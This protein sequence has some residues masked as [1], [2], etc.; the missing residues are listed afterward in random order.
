[1]STYHSWTSRGQVTVIYD[2]ENRDDIRICYG[3]TIDIE[4]EL[5]A[6]LIDSLNEALITQKRAENSKFR[7]DV[8]TGGEA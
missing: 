3:N 2:P 6:G 5:V 8:P 1:M 4:P 7:R